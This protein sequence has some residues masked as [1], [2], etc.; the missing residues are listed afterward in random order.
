MA[1]TQAEREAFLKQCGLDDCFVIVRPL[2]FEPRRKAPQGAPDRL[3]REMHVFN[4]KDAPTPG[5]VE[6]SEWQS[7]CNYL[8]LAAYV[9][10]SERAT[11]NDISRRSFLTT[12][13]RG[14]LEETWSSCMRRE[15][16]SHAAR[17]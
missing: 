16:E 11:A 14:W 3:F 13:A 12:E 7:R 17:R 15:Q 8:C 6:L 9:T 2:L 10:E 1:W 5:R 4:K